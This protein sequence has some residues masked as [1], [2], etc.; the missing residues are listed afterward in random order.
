[1]STVKKFC[2]KA[3]KGILP[4]GAVQVWKKLRDQEKAQAAVPTPGV[5]NVEDIAP[6]IYDENVNREYLRNRR[7]YESA[8]IFNTICDFYLRDDGRGGKYF[9]VNGIK[10]PDIRNEESITKDF[11]VIFGDTFLFHLFHNDKYDVQLAKVL[12]LYLQEGPYFY[13]DPA[14]RFDVTIT[15]GDVVLDVGAWIGDFSAYAAF[16]GAQVYA[17]EGAQLQ[18]KYLRQ[19]V[20]LNNPDKIKIVEKCASNQCA[21]GSILTEAYSAGANVLD[22]RQRQNAHEKVELT[23]I[24]AFVAENHLEKVNFIKADIEGHER[25][26]LE[27]AQATLR[28]FAPK[29]AICTYHNP[30]DPEVLEELILRA[31]PAY[32]VVHLRHKLFACVPDQ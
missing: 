11:H 28:E 14:N 8:Y 32:K 9:D 3:I 26:M 30:E 17:F 31:N 6:T 12:D 16:L 13:S 25:H 20:A 19:T 15:P 1:M 21:M 24:D 22:T 4:Y 10:L 18:L 5:N 7:I 29:L 23:T 27:G 2:K